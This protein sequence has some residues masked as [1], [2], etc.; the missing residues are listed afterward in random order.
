MYAQSYVPLAPPST[1]KRILSKFLNA[2]T[3]SKQP[4]VADVSTETV[5]AALTDAHTESEDYEV[6]GESSKDIGTELHDIVTIATL[7]VGEESRGCD[8]VDSP[9]SRKS[10]TKTAIPVHVAEACIP[11]RSPRRIGAPSKSVFSPSQDGV[12]KM[13][14]AGP[15]AFKQFSTP[16]SKPVKRQRRDPSPKDSDENDVEMKVLKRKKMESL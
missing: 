8:Q 14:A 2:F 13:K 7:K 16:T 4:V 12:R 11:R 10:V 5:Q 3:P 1:T 15:D 9:C 6:I